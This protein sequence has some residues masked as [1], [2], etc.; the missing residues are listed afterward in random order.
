MEKELT[1]EQAVEKLQNIVSSL[2]S[3][4]ATLEESV[5]MYEEAFKLAKICNDKLENAK[6][7]VLK[8]DEFLKENAVD[9]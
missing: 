5:N 6:Q 9:E 7:K 2:E 3:G 4:E 1:Y 8:I